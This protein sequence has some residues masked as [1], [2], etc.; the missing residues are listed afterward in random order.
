MVDEVSS[1]DIPR[2]LGPTAQLFSPMLLILKTIDLASEIRTRIPPRFQNALR[3]IKLSRRAA[4][5]ADGQFRQLHLAAQRD[6]TDR[7]RESLSL[8]V[9]QRIGF[10]GAVQ[11]KRE[12][13]DDYAIQ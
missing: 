4:A 8:Q 9:G 11:F 5:A 1:L 2:N 13:S 10:A 7:I 3:L 12:N 6:A